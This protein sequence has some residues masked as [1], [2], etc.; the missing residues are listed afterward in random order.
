[1]DPFYIALLLYVTAVVLVFID[2]F[3]PSG[4]LL[5]IMGVV[6]ATACVLF[7]FRS[8]TT[9]GMTMLTVVIGSVPLLAMAAIKIWPMTPIGRRVILRTPGASE[10]RSSLKD[11][12]GELL[13]IVV[14]AEF[15]LRPSGEIRIG[16]KRFNVIARS[17]VVDAGERVEVVGFR[18]RNLLVSRTDR[19]ISPNAKQDSDGTAETG[20]SGDEASQGNLLDLPADE[21]GLDSID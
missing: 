19:P 7:A 13:G 6:S 10:S 2:L 12:H 18:D 8:S 9:M 17:G 15:P 21:L 16:D 11:E 14:E 20:S 4:G 1:M 3:I 5:V